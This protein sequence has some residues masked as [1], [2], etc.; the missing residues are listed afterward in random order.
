MK[1]LK[2]IF[3]AVLLVL[4]A[5]N[6]QAQTQ[7]QAIELYNNGLS[8][9]Q[10]AEYQ[11]AINTFGQVITI[12]N[13]LGPDGEEVL[14]N[15]QNQ[16]LRAYYNLAVSDYEAFQSDRSIANIES[17]L[18]SFRDLQ[19]VSDDYGNTSYKERAEAII[20][21]LLYAKASMHYSA[22]E[23]ELSEAE[24]DRALNLNS[25]YAAAYFLKA[26]IFKKINDTEGDGIIDENIDQMLEWFDRAIQV[27]EATGR[28]NIA[29]RAREAAHDE[30]LAVGAN[31]INNENF[32]N[33]IQNLELALDYNAESA[34]VYFRLAEANN[35]T[36]N[37]DQALAHATTALEYET[38]G[39]TDL[40]RIY[41]ELGYAHQTL[42]N[43][44]EACEA[45]SNAVYGSFKDN[46]E[47]IMEHELKCESSTD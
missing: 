7:G 1:F 31:Y 8:E 26:R 9:A 22:D 36:G 4:I 30:L 42:G 17:T 3:S 40:A 21:Q 46:A 14:E 28:N 5:T 23:L 35:G 18:N 47:Y 45:L 10:S 38:G 32:R 43:N 6:I 39:R 41:F 37:P 20:P 19:Q 44:V 2:T 15:A 34:D 13:Q 27:A 16:L 12:A 33:A 29:S 25:N 11:K 24:V